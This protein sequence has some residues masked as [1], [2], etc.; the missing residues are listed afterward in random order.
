M[1]RYKVSRYI[2]KRYVHHWLSKMNWK[3]FSAPSEILF[4]LQRWVSL[5]SWQ[6][7]LLRNLDLEWK[8]PAKLRVF[9]RI[10]R[11]RVFYKWR[12]A[13]PEIFWEEMTRARHLQMT[14]GLGVTQMTRASKFS[15]LP[16]FQNFDPFS[17]FLTHLQN[18][19]LFSK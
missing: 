13:V 18:N 16:H 9:T 10:W 2:A 5:S 12:A 1:I 17:N 15:I 8:A 7:V 4:V 3:P 14:R 11:A 19:E 6:L